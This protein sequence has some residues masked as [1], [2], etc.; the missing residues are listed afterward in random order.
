MQNYSDTFL[1]NRYLY[2]L[3]LRHVRNSK[4]LFPCH[5]FGEK[6]LK[7]YSR[8]KLFG[9][10]ADANWSVTDSNKRLPVCD[11][12]NNDINTTPKAIQLSTQ[13]QAKNIR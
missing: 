13:T 3:G 8:R 1:S 9:V 2:V 10:V 12:L 11:W 6:Q 4:C 5:V 7:Q